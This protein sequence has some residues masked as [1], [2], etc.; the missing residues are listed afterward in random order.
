MAVIFPDW[1][2]ALRDPNESRVVGKW[3]YGP[4]PGTQP[5]AIGGYGWAVNAYSEHKLAAF[6]FAHWATSEEVQRKIVEYGA[7]LS[8]KSVMQDPEL[9]K[10]Y[11]YLQVLTQAASRACPPMKIESYFELCDSL[12]RHLSEGLTGDKSPQDVLEQAQKEWAG[13]LKRQLRK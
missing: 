1:T 6:E 10:Q 9:N 4:I 7:T 2:A 12:T 11:P 8:R 5:T 3:I 13:I